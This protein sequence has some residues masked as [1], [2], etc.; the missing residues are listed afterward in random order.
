MAV[1][2]RRRD[3]FR[4]ASGAGALGLA[5]EGRA[6]PQ[7]PVAIS[8]GNGMKAT[9]KA[10]EVLL[11]DGSPL[12]AVISGVNIVEDDPEDFSVG[13]GGLPNEDG[14]V[15]LDACVMDGRSCGSGAVGALRN[16]RNPSKVARL[17]MER[18]DHIFLVGHGALDFA[19]KMGFE[20][21]DLL[22]QE[23][24]RRWLDW[25]SKLTD[26]DNWLQEEDQATEFG[27]LIRHYG[28]ISCLALDPAGNLAGTTTTSGLAWKLPGRVGDS[29]IIGA[30]LYVDNKVGAAGSTGRGEANI[31]VC[32]SHTVVE[33]MRQGKSPQQSCI[34]TLERVIRTTKEK[35]LLGSDRRP[36]F[37]LNFY[38]LNNKG[39][40][41]AASI[42][43][44]QFVVNTGRESS[45]IDTAF[46]Y[47]RRDH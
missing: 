37:N 17:V 27:G 26:R 42:Y 1:E 5:S 32:G 39:E 30:G 9:A 10:M 47:H 34:E 16:I 15:E 35:R 45:L 22:T 28:T 21:Q 19:L 3:F 12:D 6:S 20:K 44:S 14:V 31:K 25:K 38:A 46:L 33:L 36:N 43:P 13:Y 11:R 2:I 18:T 24:R 41:G 4:M 23:S 40:Y 7:P 29:P 8:S